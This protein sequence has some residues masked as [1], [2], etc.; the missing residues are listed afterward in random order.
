MTTA[1]E[2]FSAGEMEEMLK[3]LEVYRAVIA[4]QLHTLEIQQEELMTLLA[5]F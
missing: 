1:A 2:T 4:T 3:T 5:S